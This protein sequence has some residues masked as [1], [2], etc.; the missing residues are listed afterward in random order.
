L[1]EN[2][3]KDV[4]ADSIFLPHYPEDKKDQYQ[5]IYG[6]SNMFLFMTFFYSIYERILK[7]KDLISEK[8]A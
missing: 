1:T 7:G 5:L 4:A 8:I 3:Q 6:P 2:S